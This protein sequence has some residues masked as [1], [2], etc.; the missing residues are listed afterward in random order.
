MVELAALEKRY[1]ESYRGFESLSLRQE[2]DVLYGR[3]FL[4]MGR[5]LFLLK[6]KPQYFAGYC[7]ESGLLKSAITWAAS[8]TEGLA[9]RRR[10][11]AT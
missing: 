5:R 6:N 8:N 11:S 2:N 3:L 7:A 10:V 4:G 1:S 9:V